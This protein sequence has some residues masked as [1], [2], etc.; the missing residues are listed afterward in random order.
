MDAFL[1]FYVIALGLVVGSYLNVVI[2]RLPRGTSTVL[3]RSA[4]PFCGSL[5]AAR[6]NLPLISFLLLRGRCRH[7]RS[8]I[9]W[10]YPA[11]EAAT[12][13]LFLF[14]YR[15]FGPSPD[16]FFRDGTWLLAAAFGCLLLALAGIDLEHL[17]LPDRLTLPGI[18]AGLLLQPWLPWGEAQRAALAAAWPAVAE[19][20]PEWFQHLLVGALGAL[21]GAGVLL[22]VY[23]G[24]YLLRRT[25]GLGLGDVKMLA[26]I[27]AFLGWTGVLGT[28]LVATFTAS[29]V[30]IVAMLLGRLSL[31]HKMA[32]G[33]FLT[34]GALVSLLAVG[35]GGVLG[36]LTPLLGW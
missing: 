36:L 33:P 16:R 3:P 11:L 22:A 34:L 31:Q 24:W 1:T 12:A 5:I 30:A 8:P 6:D 17:L 21:A 27:G 20:L 13:L 25:E 2:H 19:A 35:R 9:A 26:M 29:T 15:A 10:R 4:C 7:C 18:A 23:G 32:F 28:L 14:C